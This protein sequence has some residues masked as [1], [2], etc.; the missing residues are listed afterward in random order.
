MNYKKTQ[1]IYFEIFRLEN[2]NRK[3]N[4]TL[5]FIRY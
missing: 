4:T 3:K 1:K 5:Y 2:E